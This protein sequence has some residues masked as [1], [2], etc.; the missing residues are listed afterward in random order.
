MKIKDIYE[1]FDE[2]GCCTFTTLENGF[3]VSRIAHFIAYDEG[4]LYFSTM[5][6]KPFYKQLI[7]N[8]GKISV[9]GMNSSTHV[10]EIDAEN[11]KFEAGF[12]VRISGTATEIP[13]ATLK[14]K[15]DP[16]FHYF[17]ADQ[18]RYPAMVAFQISDFSGEIYDYDFEK[19]HRDHKLERKRFSFGASTIVPIGFEIQDNCINC[20]KCLKK[21][22]FSALE[23]GEHKPKQRRNRCDECGDCVLVCPQNAIVHKG[24]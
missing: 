20:G 15:N 12:F 13:T 11:I 8:Q 19:E 6:T 9:C 14:S 18:S 10:T 23:L 21:C 17:L 3:P 5:N 1:A 22:S 2:I 7:E 16:I 4:G 24:T